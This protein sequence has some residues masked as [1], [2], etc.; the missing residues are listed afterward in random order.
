MAK[1]LQRLCANDIEFTVPEGGFFFWCKLRHT[2]TSRRLLQEAAKN[3]ISFVPGEAFHAG[4]SPDRKF[5]LC[6]TT[7][8]EAVLLES[9][10]R[11]AKALTEITKRDYEND[12]TP[13]SVRPII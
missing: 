6:F 12:S 3:K 2:V 5:R 1:A 9:V 8:N 11:L 13:S 10:Q 4:S 7:H